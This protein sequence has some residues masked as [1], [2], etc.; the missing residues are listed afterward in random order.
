VT[1]S[2]E[3]TRERVVAAAAALFAQKGYHATGVAELGEVVGLGKGAL[4]R[5]IGNKENLLYTISSEQVQRMNTFAERVTESKLPAIDMLYEL[6]RGLVRN[7][8]EHR[9][10]WIV[11]FAEYHALSGSRRDKVIAAREKYEGY[12]RLALRQGR[13]E[14]TLTSGNQLLVKQ[15]L[16]MLNYT[17][18]WFEPTGE[19]TPEQLS[20]EFMSTLLD[21]IC[22]R[23]DR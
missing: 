21:G 6:G 17:Y 10:E 14:G 4:Y 11:F 1:A 20:D 22:V 23:D 8:A 12:W 16:G 2:F 18:L 5:Y 19:L 9:N 15:I 13:K 7:I 3:L